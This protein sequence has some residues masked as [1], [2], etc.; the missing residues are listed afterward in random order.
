MKAFAFRLEQALR[1]RATQ[2]GARKSRVAAAA[3]HASGLLTQLE[4]ARAETAS[5]AEEIIRAPTSQALSFYA[6]FVDR[7]RNRILGL[8]E[9]LAAAERALAVEMDLL[10]AANRKLRLIENLKQSE[11]TR[12]RV[13]F[14]RELAAFADEA[15]LGAKT[16]AATTRPTTAR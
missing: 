4:S 11:Q 1:W 5:G 2:V 6:G 3:A 8:Q 13:E 16:R 12:W 7:S 14:D 15:W 10:V 9:K